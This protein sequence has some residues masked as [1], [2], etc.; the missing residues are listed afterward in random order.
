MLRG[1]PGSTLLP[2]PTLFR[3][4]RKRS[5]AIGPPCGGAGARRTSAASGGS[6]SVAMPLR[7][8]DPGRMAERSEEHTSELQSCQYLVCRLLLEKQTT[9]GAR[10][11]DGR[12]V[13][14]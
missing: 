3:S 11:R 2:Y 9:N 8:Y 13:F 5:R 6:A 1:P 10:T 14:R 4:R 12:M 7:S